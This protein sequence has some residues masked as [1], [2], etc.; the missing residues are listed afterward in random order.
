MR[1]DLFNRRK[2]MLTLLAA[3]NKP[4]VVFTAVAEEF[5][6][7]RETVRSDYKNMK[8]WLHVVEQEEKATPI[9]FEGMDIGVRQATDLLL[10]IQPFRQGAQLTV[11][12]CFIKIGALTVYLKAVIE[13]TKFK[14]SIGLIT[15]KPQEIVTFD[16]SSEMPFA[17]NPDIKRVLLEKAQEQRA[18]K[19]LRDKARAEDAAKNNQAQPQAGH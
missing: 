19:E 13:D 5:K 10:S 12:Q 1:D 11:K 2:R 3:R 17:C 15:R 18:Q 6:V 14:Q 4:N 7:P 9:A 8:N 16:A